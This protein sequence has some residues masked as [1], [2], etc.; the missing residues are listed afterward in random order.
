MRLNPNTSIHSPACSLLG[1]VCMVLVKANLSND[2]ALEPSAA[3]SWH[4]LSGELALTLSRSAFLVFD[5]VNIWTFPVIL[6]V[7]VQKKPKTNTLYI[8]FYSCIVL[9]PTSHS[10]GAAELRYSDVLTTGVESEAWL[11]TTKSIQKPSDD[12]P[13]L[14]SQPDGGSLQ[15]SSSACV[16]VA[17]SMHLFPRN[18]NACGSIYCILD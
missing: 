10:S 1:V 11:L 18:F 9:I 13:L 6:E 3:I 8:Y 4:W 14:T 12:L 17:A 2:V 15:R 7:G 5:P 16:C